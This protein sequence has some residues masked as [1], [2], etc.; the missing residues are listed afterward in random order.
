I[1]AKVDNITQFSDEL[2]EQEDIVPLVVNG[3]QHHIEELSN[4]R[5]ETLNGIKENLKIKR[6]W[7]DDTLDDIDLKLEDM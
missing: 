5:V 2:I 3:I 4:I 7:V 6:N 1:L